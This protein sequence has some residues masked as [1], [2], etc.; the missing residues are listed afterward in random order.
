MID[1]PPGA[2]AFT[3]CQVPVVYR[4]AEGAASIGVAARAGGVSDIPGDTLPAG[5]SAEVF[6]RSGRVTRIDVVV[7]RS[8]ILH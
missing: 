1:L 7:P 5:V 6:A 4:L 8:S 3:V 2:I